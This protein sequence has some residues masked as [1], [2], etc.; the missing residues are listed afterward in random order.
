MTTTRPTAPQ[1]RT[2]PEKRRV[3]GWEAGRESGRERLPPRPGPPPPDPLAGPAG[4]AALRGPAAFVETGRLWALL[5][6][7]ADRPSCALGRFLPAPALS[8]LTPALPCSPAITV[9]PSVRSAPS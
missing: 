9:V 3:G 2:A 5:C 8:P 1:A 6:S 7:L 4:L